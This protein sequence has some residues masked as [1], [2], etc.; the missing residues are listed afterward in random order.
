MS[1]Q[2]AGN[3][4]IPRTR[5]RGTRAAAALAAAVVLAT[6]LSSCA[7]IEGP[8][9]KTPERTVAPPP[10]QQPELVP[11]GT[12]D[13]NLTFFT[14]TLRKYAAGDGAIQ[15]QPVVDALVDAGFEKSHMQVSYDR[16]R[17]DLVADNIFVSVLVGQECLIGQI[18]TESRDVFVEAGEA[19]GPNSDICLIGQTRPIDW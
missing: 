17:T 11:D 2:R 16:T 19:L 15:G 1:S 6:G 8:T 9:P 4:T 18:V 7:L 5:V 3:A 12:A 10:E 13:D 14:E